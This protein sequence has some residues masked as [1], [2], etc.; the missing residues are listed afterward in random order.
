MGP[1]LA[2]EVESHKPRHTLVADGVSRVMV[3]G[4]G[5][6]TTGSGQTSVRLGRGLITYPNDQPFESSKHVETGTSLYVGLKMLTK[7]VVKL[8]RGRRYRSNNS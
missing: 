4:R 1:V 8:E 5:C 7:L 6:P 3:P 2:T